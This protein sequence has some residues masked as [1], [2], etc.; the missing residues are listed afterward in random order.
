MPIASMA[1]LMVLAVYMPPHEPAPGH[2]SHSIACSFFSSILPAWNLPTASK[3][4]TMSTSSP[5][6]PTPG[7][8][9]PP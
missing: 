2:D 3:I 4:E 1:E 7:R 9:L 5:S 6:G 8:M